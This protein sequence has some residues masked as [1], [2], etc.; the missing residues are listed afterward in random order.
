MSDSISPSAA[1]SP[2]PTR[3]DS[4]RPGA[5]PPTTDIA[6][7]SPQRW[8]A[9]WVCVTVA[10]ITILDLSKVNVALPSIESALGAGSTELQLIVSG[11]VLTFGLV[12]VPMGRL[13]DQRSRR[14]LFIV[15]LSLFTVTSVVCALAI[16]PVMLLVGRLLQGV[17]AGIQMPQVLGLIQQLFQGKERG[18]AFGLFG[19][20]VGIATAFGPTLGGLLIL[21]GGPTDGWRWIFWVNVPLCLI[22]IGLTVWLLPRTRTPSRRALSFDLFGV[23]LFGLAVLSLMWPFLFTT[24]S[25]DDDPRR[26]WLLVAFVLFAGAF[27]AW[28][29]HYE[30]RGKQPLIRFALFRISSFRNGT[31]LIAAYFTA[32]PALF[33]LTTLF[34]QTGL[35]LEPVFA[36][37]V[38]IGFALAN[39]LFSWIGGN[40]VGTYGRP[41]VVWGLVGV[42]LCVLGLAATALFV[43]QEWVA[44]VM[45]GVMVL[46]GAG[47]GLVLSPNQTLTL[48]DIPVK[49]GGIAGS[50]GQL[51]QRIG[52]SIG[53]AVGLSLF[54]ATIYR[55]QGGAAS[56]IVVYHDAYA[57]G[58][59]AVALF[60]AVAFVIAVIDLSSR[61]RKKGA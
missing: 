41:I 18:R 38:T 17:A 53:T 21:L 46:G 35:G 44:W 48:A 26:W 24:G 52:S 36:G 57:Y 11:Y 3:A 60:V 28:E 7:T 58:L 42:L 22:A 33:L 4:A 1:A 31:F 27:V 20:T 32:I 25:P 54:Y 50:I 39:A 5:H 15:G 55:E 2:A 12:L 51:G 37:M 9:F 45:A 47:G 8:R 49:Q 23:F 59:T 34:L 29:R 56:D 19:A 61:R 30:A 16:N 40:L 13:G 10:A 6:L 43:P 14:G